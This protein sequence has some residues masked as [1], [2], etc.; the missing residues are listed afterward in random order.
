MIDRK[1]RRHGAGESDSRSAFARDRDR[2]LYCSAFRRLGGVSQVVAA[3][4]GEVF[5]NRL[6]HSIKVGQVARRLAERLRT[7]APTDLEGR[8]DAEVAEAAALAHDTGHPPFGH[9]AEAELHRLAT[10][11]GADGFEGNAQSFRILVRLAVR[12]EEPRGLNLTRGVLDAC[13]KYPWFRDDEHPKARRK[14]GAYRSEERDFRFARGLSE[15]DHIPAAD[16]AAPRLEAQIMDL[17]DDIT[18]AVHD[19]ETSCGLASFRCIVREPRAGEPGATER[20]ELALWIRD[21]WTQSGTS[22]AQPDPDAIARALRNTLGLYGPSCPYEPRGGGVRRCG[23]SS[24]RSSAATS[25]TLNS[26]RRARPGCPTR[27]PWNSALSKS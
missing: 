1:K 18:Y 15:T 26:P 14:W 8:P 20:R 3:G 7:E 4:E 13:L 11:D 2:V 23:T 12:E 24:L 19:I 9:V 6:T 17:A 22:Q 25:N 16:A 10:A 5:H 21:K 27:P